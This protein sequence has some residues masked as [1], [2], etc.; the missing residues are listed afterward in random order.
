MRIT[1]LLTQSLESPSGLGRYWPL[2]KELARLGHKVTILALHHDFRALKH[3]EQEFVRDGVR[4][5]YV[6]QMHVR[7][8]GNIKYYFGSTRLVWIAT[9]ATWQLMKAALQ[10]P[11]D[12]YHLG[13][14]HPMNGLAILLPH[15]LKGKPI[16]LDYDDY[17][18]V[19]NR[20]SSDWQRKIVAFFEDGL[21]RLAAGITVNTHFTAER[22]KRLGYPADRIV[23]VPNGVDRDRFSAVCSA[24]AAALRQHLGLANRKVILYLGSLSLVS[25]PL[26]LLIEAFA[27][28]RQA[29]PETVL[30]LVGGGEDYS[31]LLR[32]VDDLG[33]NDN[34]R[35]MG[36][37]P[38]DRVPIYYFLSDVSVD[39]VHNDLIARARFPLK[40]VESLA[41]GTPV[42][43]GDVGDR[44]ELLEEGR[45]GIL[46]PPGS[47]Q[48]LADGLLS[49]LQDSNLRAYI[50]QAVLSRRKQWYWDHL[51]YD[52]I[53]VYE[54][55]A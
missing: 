47:A 37:V 3:Q 18:A 13:K 26:D 1:F 44:R 40:I 39:P 25:H 41:S 30:L 29:E 36:W 32:R 45:L 19:S 15:L 10:I 33:L 14:P 38:P 35:F 43:T 8:L 20:F 53:Q 6:G 55:T 11:T 27:I 34:V 2:S 5:H 24:D 54:E 17:E 51:V 4:V 9:I 7:K 23:Y 16:Y 12:V 42:V 22:L 31:A 46:V 28:V 49:V 21:P 48:A 52:F 50:T